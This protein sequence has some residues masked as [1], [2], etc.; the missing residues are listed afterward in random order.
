MLDFCK[1][2]FPVIDFD[3][4]L[5]RSYRNFSWEEQEDVNVNVLKF[6][7]TLNTK[8]A[9]STNTNSIGIVTSLVVTYTAEKAFTVYY[10][11][12]VCDAALK[13]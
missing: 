4:Y 13:K 9:K 3:P 6:V 11:Y 8:R 2:L 1:S 10:F 5:S 12:V 7:T